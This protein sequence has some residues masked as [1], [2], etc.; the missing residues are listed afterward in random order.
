MQFSIASNSSKSLT[1]I[2]DNVSCMIDNVFN[3]NRSCFKNKLSSRILLSYEITS[4]PLTF[5]NDVYDDVFNIKDNTVEELNTMLSAL[6]K[7]DYHPE[8]Q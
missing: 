7:K 2:N 6:I 8:R 5:V 4:R 1:P 3:P